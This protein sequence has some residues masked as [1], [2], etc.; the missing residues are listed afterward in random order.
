ML[1]PGNAPRAVRV[2]CRRASSHRRLV[3]WNHTA[4]GNHNF[5][6]VL[7]NGGTFYIDDGKPTPALFDATVRN[8][9]EIPAVAHFTVPRTYEMLLPIC[10]AMPCSERRSSS[11]SNSVRR[12]GRT[13]P[14]LLGRA[15]RPSDGRL[16]RRDPDRHRARRNRDRALRA[17]DRWLGPSTGMIGLPCPGMELKLVPAE[18]KR[19]ARVRGPNITPGYWRDQALTQAAFDEEGF[20]KLGDAMEFARPCRS[21]QGPGVQRPHRRRLQALDGNMGQRR[22][23]A[24][25]DPL[26]A[27]GLAQDVVIG[28]ARQRLR[29]CHGLSQP[30]ALP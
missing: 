4:G 11:S 19:K 13:R 10:A 15:A 25:E 22:S 12:R 5:G 7:Y 27:A 9:R 24:R 14:A 17:G 20:Y 21:P 28:G 16:R 8:L 2:S 29:R 18:S 26:P 30:R 6:I 1:Q 23:A 3:P